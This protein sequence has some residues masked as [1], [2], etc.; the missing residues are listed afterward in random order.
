LGETIVEIGQYMP[1][2]ASDARLSEPALIGND[3]RQII[4]T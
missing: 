2:Q 4:A 1:R 3:H